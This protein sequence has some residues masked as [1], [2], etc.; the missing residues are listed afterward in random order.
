M[1]CPPNAGVVSIVV[2]AFHCAAAVAQEVPH[3]KPGLWQND[4]V[5]AGQHVSNQS[6]VD[7]ASEAQN[8][9]FSAEV[10]K[11]RKCQHREITHNPDGSWTSVSTCESRP[12]VMRTSRADVSGDL[13]SKI[14]LTMRS[15]PDA[16]PEMTM[17]STWIGPC[18]PGQKGG[19]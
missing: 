16:P 15:P 10:S 8:S 7:A 19:D 5:V 2:L 3:Q 17:T 11:N 6:C 18:K 13:N 9:A 12:G 1:R 14:T 4:M